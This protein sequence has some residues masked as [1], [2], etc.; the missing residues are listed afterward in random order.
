MNTILNRNRLVQPV[1]RIMRQLLSGFAL[2]MALRENLHVA[3]PDVAHDSSPAALGLRAAVK[4]PRDPAHPE[5]LP[6]NRPRQKSTLFPAAPQGAVWRQ[7]SGLRN[8]ERAREHNPLTSANSPRSAPRPR[9]PGSAIGRKPKRV[10]GWT[11]RR[12]KRSRLGP[13]K[14]SRRK[15]ARSLEASRRTPGPGPP[16]CLKRCGHRPLP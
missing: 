7:V 12:S 6:T 4:Y 10:C 16:Q 13:R 9:A 5:W 1:A 3:K 8:K 14:P 11:A 15:A 2:P